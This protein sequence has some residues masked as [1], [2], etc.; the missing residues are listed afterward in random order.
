MY[1]VAIGEVSA[2]EWD[3]WQCYGGDKDIEFVARIIQRP[4]I[5]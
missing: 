4:L 1:M 3:G 2:T 5:V